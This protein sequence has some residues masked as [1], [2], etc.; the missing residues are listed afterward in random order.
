[1]LHIDGLMQKSR[2][3]SALALEV[4]FHTVSTC[5]ILSIDKRD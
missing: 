3:S 2:N 5:Y 4:K 1:M